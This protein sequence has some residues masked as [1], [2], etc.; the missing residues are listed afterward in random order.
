MNRIALFVKAAIVGLL[1]LLLLIPLAMINGTIAERGRYRQEAIASVARSSAGAQTV[2]GP[3]LVVPYEDA[4]RYVGTDGKEIVSAPH[5]RSR[6]LVFPETLTLEGNVDTDKRFVG[7]H[8]VRVYTLDAKLA[9]RFRPDLAD[10]PDPNVLR[11]YG[12]PYLSFSF[13]DVRGLGRTSLLVDGKPVALRQGVGEHRDDGGT[14]AP[15][16]ALVPGKALVVGLAFTLDGTE[17]LAIV[18]IGDQNAIHVTSD[19]QHPQFAGSF[20]PSVKDRRIDAKGFDARWNITALAA[21]S[22]RQYREDQALDAIEKLDVGLVEPVNIYTQA[23]RASKYG[24]LFVALTFVG[25]AMFE[26]I[27]RLPIHPIQYGLVGLALAIFF[28]LLLSLSEHYAFWKA[29]LAASTACI[30]LLGYYLSA[31][32]RSR[33]R[34]LGFA[35]MLTVLY[36]ALYGL[37]VSEDNALVLGSGLLFAALAAVMVLTRRIDWYA[38]GKGEPQAAQA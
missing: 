28:L 35:A 20:L 33:A 4:R 10:A 31:V 9:A 17:S 37:L 19:W 16:P 11:T 2:S 15:L 23:D 34:G 7:L 29:Y 5:A 3:V 8:E 22:Q 38:L 12:T 14:H 27:K 6:M 30:G 13:G 18:P 32:L 26:L 21:S 1:T 25:F 36:G 24:I